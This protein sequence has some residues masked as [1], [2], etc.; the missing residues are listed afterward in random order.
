MVIEIDG[1]FHQVLLI[2][3]SCSM[4][5]LKKNYFETKELITDIKDLPTMLCRLHQFKQIPYDDRIQVSYRID[6]DTDRI[7]SPT[8]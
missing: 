2:G 8:Y 7:Y 5:E 1:Y 4:E 6:T 3:T